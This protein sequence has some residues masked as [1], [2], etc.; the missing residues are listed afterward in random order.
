MRKYA[1]RVKATTV[2]EG[3]RLCFRNKRADVTVEATSVSRDG[4]VGLHANG[5]TWSSWY[6]PDE[7]VSIAGASQARGRRKVVHEQGEA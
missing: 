7:W 1:I 4:R 5:G 6:A 2:G 3:D